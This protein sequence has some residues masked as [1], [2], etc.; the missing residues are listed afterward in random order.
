MQRIDY[1]VDFMGESITA[2]VTAANC[3]PSLEVVNTEIM[4]KGFKPLV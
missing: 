4:N 3:P 2:L 1:C